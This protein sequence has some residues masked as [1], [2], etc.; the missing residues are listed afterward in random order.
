MPITKTIRVELGDRSY[1]VGVGVDVL[2]AVGETA[3][4]VAASLRAVVVTDS[5]VRDLSATSVAESMASAGLGVDV[6]DFPAGEDRKD[7]AASADCEIS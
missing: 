1:D 7:L 6:I 3:A 2:G 4:A 5:N